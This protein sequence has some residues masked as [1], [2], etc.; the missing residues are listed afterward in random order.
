MTDESAI[1]LGQG[2]VEQL[3]TIVE[4][5]PDEDVARLLGSGSLDRLIGHRSK[6]H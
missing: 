1:E 4:E 5:L 3:S 6:R 2:L